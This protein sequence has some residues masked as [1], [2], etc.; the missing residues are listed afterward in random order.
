MEELD[1]LVKQIESENDFEKVVELFGAAAGLVKSKL[2]SAT[3]SKGKILEII[4]EL[5]AFIEK[6]LKC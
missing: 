1:K 4:G 3:K 2:E 6:E 5:D